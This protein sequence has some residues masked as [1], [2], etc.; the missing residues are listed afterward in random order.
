MYLY[1][2]FANPLGCAKFGFK[3][4]DYVKAV[5]NESGILHAVA[6]KTGVAMRVKE[7]GNRLAIRSM[8]GQTLATFKNSTN[9]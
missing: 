7:I 2:D 5:R 6:P 4:G 8:S 1:V 9:C 3:R